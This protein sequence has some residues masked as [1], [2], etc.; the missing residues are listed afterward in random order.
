MN[1]IRDITNDMRELTKVEDFLILQK[2]VKGLLKNLDGAPD[3]RE[4]AS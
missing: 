1:D 3:R 2:D 4:V